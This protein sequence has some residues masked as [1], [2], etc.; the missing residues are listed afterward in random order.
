MDTLDLVVL[1]TAVSSILGGW[2]LGLV[3]RG[4]SWVG[5]AVGLFLAA[6][7]LPD[8]VRAAEPDQPARALAIVVGV[9]IGGAF[10][11]QAVGLAIGA[12]FHRLLPP[13]P[14]RTVDRGL[15]A[16]AEIGRAHV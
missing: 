6:R 4:L 7:F 8:I 9:L 15:G 2:R 14:M 3:A 11:G 1:L 12:H 5:L 13:G 10:V 16:A